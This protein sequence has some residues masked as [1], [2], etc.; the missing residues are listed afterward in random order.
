MGSQP[1]IGLILAGEEI[2]FDDALQRIRCYPKRTLAN[3]DRA[4][5][6]GERVRDIII[7]T[8]QLASRISDREADQLADCDKSAPW[9]AVPA[10][11]DLANIE[12]G[13]SEWNRADALYLH[14]INSG[15]SG[16]A[17]AKVHKYLHLRRPSL[18]PILDSRVQSF[19]RPHKDASLSL[20]ASS[21][22]S[23]RQKI[24]AM[25]AHDVRTNRS[26]GTLDLLRDASDEK[27]EG[28]TDLRVLDMLVWSN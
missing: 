6:N 22:L 26:N 13:S 10:D 11:M 19:Y 5:K 1:N 24:W 9:D 20:N 7:R 12:V 18:Y 27:L 3:Y 23:E 14:F 8:R 15:I 16:V 21:Q 4:A 2:S 17:M 28:I 25:I